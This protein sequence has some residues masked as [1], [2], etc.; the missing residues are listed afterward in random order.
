VTRFVG[1]AK[2]AVPFASDML[3]FAL[4]DHPRGIGPA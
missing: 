1:E 3:G 2:A 4:D